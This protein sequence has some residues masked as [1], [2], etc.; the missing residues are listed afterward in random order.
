M[1]AMKKAATKSNNKKIS[2]ISTRFPLTHYIPQIKIKF[3]KKVKTI[4]R[5]RLTLKPAAFRTFLYG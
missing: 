1:I 2:L 4:I 5:T 3:I